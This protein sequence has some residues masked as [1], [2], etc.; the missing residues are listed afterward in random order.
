MDAKFITF[1]QIVED[2]SDVKKLY[3]DG[4]ETEAFQLYEDKLKEIKDKTF[5]DTGELRSISIANL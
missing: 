5:K 2:F 1:A 3:Q 4:K